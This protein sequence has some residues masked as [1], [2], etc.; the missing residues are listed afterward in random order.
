MKL[1]QSMV[2]HRAQNMVCYTLC[3]GRQAHI[4][5][6]YSAL[7]QCNLLVIPATQTLDGGVKEN[8]TK[9]AIYVDCLRILD[10]VGW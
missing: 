9:F 10:P 4:D 5:L 6:P 7:L 3:A 1:S 2:S 8:A